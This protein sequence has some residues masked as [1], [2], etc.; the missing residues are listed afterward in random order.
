MHWHQLT[1]LSQISYIKKISEQSDIRAV[2]IFKHSI[3]CGISSMALSRLENKW[4]ESADTP[5]YYLEILQHR[6]ISD[7]VAKEFN[8]SH[9]SPQVL[10]IKN[11][12]CIYHQ[13]HSGIMVPDI[14]NALTK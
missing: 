11:G 9:E 14:L 3:R 6:D 7:A 5:C 2:L 1:E 10:L 4:P 12:K 8:I 13:S